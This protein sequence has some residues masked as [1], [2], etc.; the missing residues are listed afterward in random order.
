M[1]GLPALETNGEVNIMRGSGGIRSWPRKCP[2]CGKRYR[3]C[4][5][6]KRG[7]GE[8]V[9]TLTCRGRSKETQPAVEAE[10]PIEHCEFCGTDFTDECPNCFERP[11]GTAKTDAP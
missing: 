4:N 1:S 10:C 7:H 8:D 11:H 3:I 9:H 6:Q 2:Y 5:L